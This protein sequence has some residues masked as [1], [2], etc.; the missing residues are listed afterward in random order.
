MPQS[1]AAAYLHIVFSTKLREPTIDPAWANNLY[2]YLGGIAAGNQQ[3]LLASGGMPDH[4]HLLVSIG[5]EDTIAGTV[6]ALKSGSSRWLHDSG[7]ADRSFAWQAGYGAFTVSQSQIEVVTNYIRNQ[8][9]HH[10]KW[11]FQQEYR[12]LLRNHGIEFDERYV[13]D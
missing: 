11:T 8:A 3:R 12:F 5:R 13:W 10:R 6:K 2:A 7:T 9:E 1:L 4:I